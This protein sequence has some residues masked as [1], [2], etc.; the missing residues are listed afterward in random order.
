MKN[1]KYSNSENKS[2]NFFSSFFN[3]LSNY[4]AKS[5]NAEIV[6]KIISGKVDFENDF[7]ISTLGSLSNNSLPQHCDIFYGEI[8]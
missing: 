8:Y 1:I 6:N 2:S 5:K 4:Q 7:K 3:K